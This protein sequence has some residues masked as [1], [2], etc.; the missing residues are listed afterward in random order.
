[1]TSESTKCA[2][3]AGNRKELSVEHWTCT[4]YLALH[5]IAEGAE[6]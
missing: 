1:M 2:L 6:S 5:Y 4:V 3:S